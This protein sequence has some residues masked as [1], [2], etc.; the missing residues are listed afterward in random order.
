VASAAQAAKVA[1]L[2][3]DARK[4]I[5][6]RKFAEADKFLADARTLAPQDAAVLAA[7]QELDKAR[8]QPSPEEIARQKKLKEDYELAMDAGRNAV[9]KQ[10]YQGAVNAFTEA[11]RLMPDS[12]EAAEQKLAAQR[13]LAQADGQKLE[14]FKKRTAAAAAAMKDK[15]YQAAVDAYTEALKLYPTDAGA[16]AGLGAA[17]K[18]LADEATAAAE[19]KK[20]Q[21]DFDK[22]IA[23]AQA[24]MKAGQHDAAV[25]DYTDA[26]K[27]FPT[28]PTALKGLNDARKAVGDDAD[29]KKKETAFAAAL[30]AGDD[31]LKAKNFDAAIKAYTDAGAILPG[32]KRAAD[33][34]Q[35]A[36]TGK[37]ALDAEVKRKADFDK[38]MRDGGDAMSKKQYAEAVRFF[39]DAAR[40]FPTDPGAAKALKD[41]TAALEASKAP[42]KPD[43]AVEYG[44]Q[45]AAGAAA[46]RKRQW[47]D[48]MQAYKEAL[49]WMPGD[50]RATAALKSAEFSL[51]MDEGQKAAAAKRF[52]DAVKE[53]EAALRIFP[54]NK[55]A[56]A[57]LKRAKDGKP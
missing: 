28:D 41:A 11:L 51:H 49:K 42:P 54:D 8:K 38:L 56:Q 29:R 37:A 26:L 12:K 13:L 27:L 10:N 9:K 21:A 4:A 15:K 23:Q 52:P 22:L 35:A 2:V 31:A 18:A 57:A 24:A 5:G 45:M 3:A 32:D 16:L 53:Y 44:K 47:T 30:K 25:K 43:P 17:K 48:S 40:L 39:G 55:D 50:A 19:V 36:R 1:A 6:A 34:L 46:D 20:R 14:D 7:A 33:G